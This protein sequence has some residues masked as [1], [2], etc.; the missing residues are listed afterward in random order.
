[1]S[2]LWK[3]YIDFP[4]FYIGTRQSLLVLCHCTLTINNCLCLYLHFCFCI[5]LPGHIVTTIH[6]YLWNSLKVASPFPW[7]NFSLH[8]TKPDI[9][10]NILHWPITVSRVIQNALYNFV[11]IYPGYILCGYVFTYSLSI[12]RKKNNNCTL[13]VSSSRS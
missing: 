1:M 13:L 9:T 11:H 3:M 8:K 4:L 2:Y 12:K 10:S 5:T 7:W 6:S